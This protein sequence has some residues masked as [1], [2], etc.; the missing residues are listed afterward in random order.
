MARYGLQSINPTLSFASLANNFKQSWEKKW[1]ERVHLYSQIFI[2]L[3]LML[4]Q[5]ST[6]ACR[7]QKSLARQVQPLSKLIS[8]DEKSAL[9]NHQRNS[10][11]NHFP[12]IEWNWMPNLLMT[13]L[14]MWTD[15]VF[16]ILF[17]GSCEHCGASGALKLNST[18]N[19]AILCTSTFK[20]FTS[21]GAEEHFTWCT[22][23]CTSSHLEPPVQACQIPKS[24]SNHNLEKNSKQY[25]YLEI[26]NKR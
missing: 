15:S 5:L 19:L 20:F 1:N 11:S 18:Y 26:V 22:V 4:A 9:K 7:P 12:E 21:P 23:H 25:L 17:E 16:R 13:G 3:C 6:R 2:R 8:A 24:S 14:S 10:Y